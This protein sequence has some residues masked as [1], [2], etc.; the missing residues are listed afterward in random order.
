MLS[1]Q[2]MLSNILKKKYIIFIVLFLFGIFISRIVGYGDD[3]DTAGLILAYL[4]IIENGVYSPSRAYGSPLAEFL[5]GSF[6][7]F[8]GGKISALISYILFILSL[9]FLFNYFH[10]NEKTILTKKIFFF[11]ILCL[12]NPVLLFDNVNPSDYILSL[13]FF[14]FGVFLLKTNYKLFSAIFFAFCIA[15]RSNYA[16]FVI[17]IFIFEFILNRNNQNKKENILIFLNTIIIASLFYLPI[18]IQHKFKIDYIFNSGGPEI[19]LT[20][21]VPRFIYKFYLL[22]GVYNSLIFLYLSF[23]VIINNGLKNI[24]NFLSNEKKILTIITINALIFFFIPT[25]T[26]IISLA[27]ILIYFLIIKNFKQKIILTIIFFN[28]LYWI[29]SYKF[30]EFKYIN[31]NSCEPIQAISAKFNFEIQ[32]G[33]FSEKKIK[34]INTVKCYSIHFKHKNENYIKGEKLSN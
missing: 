12:S 26:A 8:I 14:S 2:L 30:L 13:F 34:I 21:L 18:T 28:I 19:L 29:V 10:R 22:L 1:I 31:N 25:K 6:S 4:N 11:L 16:I 3:L 5:I 9:I 17:T 32:Q 15:S 23:I 33:F 7:Y 24:V 27:I 20:E